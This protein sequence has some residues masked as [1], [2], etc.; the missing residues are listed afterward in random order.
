MAGFAQADVGLDNF[1]DVGLLLDGLGE[2][3]HGRILAG[4]TFE[5]KAPATPEAV[6]RPASFKQDSF[7]SGSAKPWIGRNAY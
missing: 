3:G 7:D 2:V 4:Y 6:L 5:N 1:D